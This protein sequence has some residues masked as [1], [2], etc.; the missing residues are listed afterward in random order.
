MKLY[1]TR[2]LYLHCEIDIPTSNSHKFTDQDP[3]DQRSQES[4]DFSPIL[5]R[6]LG[7]RIP[8]G[9]IPSI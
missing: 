7:L 5:K 1:E 2:K 4:I 3:V 6:I 9:L 8:A